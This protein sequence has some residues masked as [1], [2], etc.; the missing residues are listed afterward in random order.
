[1]RSISILGTGWLGLPLVDYFASRN[2]RVRASARSVARFAELE[3]AG[4]E[5]FVVDIDAASPDPGEFLDSQILIVDIPSKSVDGFR[6]LVETIGSSAIE[7]VLYTSSTSVYRNTNAAVTENEG[8]ESA[9]S[10]LFAIE[11]LFRAARGF[12]TTIVRLAGLVGYKRHPGRF[13]GPAKPIPNPDAPV[14]LVHR[15]DCV[16]VIG[17]IVEREAWGEVFNCCADEHPRKR[18]FYRRAA[19]LLGRDPPPPGT[20]GTG[21]YKI[22]VNDK[23]KKMLDYAFIYPDPMN[24]TFEEDA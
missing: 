12:D 16:A 13:F 14:N 20:A 2:Y 3:T 19:E 9:Q 1:M 6:R 22:V 17:R 21:D 5:P 4:A 7:R 10:P 15:D 8:A 23:V 18:D 11:N 24:M